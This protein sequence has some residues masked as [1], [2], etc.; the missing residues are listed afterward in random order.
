MVAC[1]S[2]RRGT[3]VDGRRGALTSLLVVLLATPALAQN[4]AVRVD[5]DTGTSRRAI[6]P[7]IYG[8]AHATQAQLQ[9]L[10]S[11]LNRRG[12]NAT[13]RY[14]WQLNADN[15]GSDFYFESLGYTSTQPGAVVD[16]FIAATRAAGAEPMV[17][18]PTLGWVAKLG[19]SRARMCSYSI[20]K[21]GAQQG[22]DAAYYPDAGNG[23][24]LDG[25]LI[26]TNNPSDANV[27]SDAT[28]Q[29]GFVEHLLER[30]GVVSSGGVRLY[31]MDNEP[32]LWHQTHRDVHPT[33]ATMQ[34]VLDK[35]LAHAAAVKALDPSALILGP[36]EWG[37]SGYLYSGYDH[38]QAQANGY[39]RYPD[40]EAHGNWDYIPW[41]LDQLR[42]NE[43]RTGRRLLDV[44]T[45]HY[46]PQG[47]EFSSDTSSAMQLRRNRS[48]RSLW[49]PNYVDET[50]IND[51]VRLIPRL[52]QWVSTYY[53]GLKVG[54]TEYN[55][56]AE[57]HISGALAQ[58]DILG[59]FGREG[60]DYA[61]RWET[62]AATTPTF[63]A[64][65]LY[66]NYDGQ[67]S[68]FGDTSVA[69]AVP[70]PD[71]LAAFAAER[72][73]DGALTVMVI[74]KAASGDTPVT[75]NLRGFNSRGTAQRWQLTSANAVTRLAD[76]SAT[77]SGLST[78]VP[79]QSI[80][81]FVLAS[82][83]GTPPPPGNQPP[84]ANFTATPSSGPAPLAVGFNGAGSL[85][86]DGTITLYTWD[87][88][89]GT[90]QTGV[91]ASHTYSQPGTYTA[92]LTVKD[93]DGDTGSA[94]TA[95]TATSASTTLAAPT[96]FNA[97][98][99]GTSAT[100]RW[101]DTNSGEQGFLLERSP[102]RWP[103]AFQEIGRVGV[104]V[105]Q[106]VDPAVP[107]GSSYYRVRAYAGTALSEPSNMDSVTR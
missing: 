91:S 17:T 19:A 5:I 96:G 101:T 103:L 15:R 18:V 38:Q 100:L 63:K 67:K 45:V 52:K 106:F 12:G 43:Q 46:Y 48:T 99:S 84:V 49:D 104:N 51:K 102:A 10:N 81:L 20:T 82:T 34:E 87:F 66:R 93:D 107:T 57:G 92:R 79:A 77:S 74:S 78:S 25:S 11:P 27:A 16:D 29:R 53:P 2:N 7:F 24:R 13:T 58:A 42:Q 8:V 80:T 41:L 75:L 37:W 44:L 61:T 95:L 32:S 73:S 94:T 65:K 9:E 85:D 89:D 88:G 71:T 60:L 21:Y 33:G 4:A 26:T 59:I 105:T 86:A 3:S 97:R 1:P 35:H 36:E 28:F 98:L 56:G 23:V 39:T 64:M 31:L 90:S 47:G 70:N 30:W 55:W 6:S 83:T 14:N 72:S 76:V 22:R 69:C 62:P 68:G 54:L 40:R 50:W